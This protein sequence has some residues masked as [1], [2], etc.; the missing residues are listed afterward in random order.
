MKRYNDF[1]EEYE[2]GYEDGRRDALMEL[3]EEE[4]I[5]DDFS[6]IGDIAV[7]SVGGRKPVFAFHRKG[8]NHLIPFGRKSSKFLSGYL[9]SFLGGS[10]AIIVNALRDRGWKG[11]VNNIY[12]FNGK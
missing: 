9:D 1:N 10:K 5:D 6:S 2:K 11:K 12:L 3:E 4:E 8:D 7:I